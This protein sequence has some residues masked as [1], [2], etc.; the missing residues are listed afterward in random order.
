M[1]C[2]IVSI[3]VGPS[4]LKISGPGEAAPDE[5]LSVRCESSPSVPPAQISWIVSQS[6]R[7]IQSEETI[8]STD[9]GSF[10]TVS[11]MNVTV[12]SGP[13]VEDIV[14]QCVATQLS[15]GEASLEAVH[16]IKVASRTS[17]ASTPGVSSVEEGRRLSSI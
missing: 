1:H 14:V 8:R 7:P 5:M 17:S 11:R 13:W 16:V 10:A 12:P 9:H 4:D 3:S 2:F 6:S 15:L